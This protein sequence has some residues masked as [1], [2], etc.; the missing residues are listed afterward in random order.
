MLKLLGAE[1]TT[2]SCHLWASELQQLLGVHKQWEIPSD[3]QSRASL[4]QPGS[5]IAGEGSPM[6][7]HQV[8][9]W[10]WGCAEARPGCQPMGW[11]CL[12]RAG[13]G[14]SQSL[15][16]YRVGV[17]VTGAGMDGLG[18]G[19]NGVPRPTGAVCRA[20]H[21]LSKAKAELLC[22]SCKKYLDFEKNTDEEDSSAG[23]G[24]CHKGKAGQQDYSIHLCCN[25]QSTATSVSDLMI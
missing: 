17:A 9:P 22:N 14:Q 3:W 19:W 23:K 18:M 5:R 25:I 15:A 11:A 24:F 2:L 20:V 8:T 13:L 1:R 6:P 10:G 4:S 16:S 7:R 21:I 12:S